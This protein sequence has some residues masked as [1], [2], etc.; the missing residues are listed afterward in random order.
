[1]EKNNDAD[2]TT[3]AID[4]A[5]ENALRKNNDAD[6]TTN[7][8]SAHASQSNFTSIHFKNY[9][10]IISQYKGEYMNSLESSLL[11]RNTS[12]T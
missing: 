9:E 4:T 1:M 6:S 8:F 11:I 5:H 7:K 12:N 10:M 2:S 3:K